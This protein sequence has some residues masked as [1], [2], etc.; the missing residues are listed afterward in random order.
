MARCGCTTECTCRLENGS[1]TTYSGTGTPADPFKIDI[2]VDGDTINC[3]PSGL[4]ATLRTIDTNTV[5][6][7]GDGTVATP[8]E[9][10]VIRTL[11]GNVPDPDAIGTGNLIKEI[12]GP[13]GGIYV[14]CED[15]QDCIGTAITSILVSDCL[16][17]DDATNTINV[18]ICAEPNGVE[19]A[20]SGD[21]DCPTGG[22]L[23][24][25]SSDTGDGLVFGTDN[26]LF[27]ASPAIQAGDCLTITGTGTNADPF[28]IFPQVAPEPNGLECVPG[29]GLLVFPSSDANNG[30]TF[31]PDQRLY[32][33]SCPFLIG[34]S[35]LLFGPASGPCF[36]IQGNGCT[37]P[38]RATLRISS[39]PC[40]GLECRADGLYVNV[41]TSATPA[42]VVRTDNTPGFPGLGPFNGTNAL[43]VVDGPVCINITNPSTCR[44]MITTVNLT[45]FTDV[46]RQSGSMSAQFEISDNAG[47]P[48][49]TVHRNAQAAPTPP[50]RHT[51]NASF[52]GN[53]VLIPPGGSRQVCVRTTVSFAGANTGRLFFSERTISLVGTWAV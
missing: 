30:L 6:L 9:A 7:E 27:F 5:D 28:V 45:G 52:Q 20:P 51:L 49:Q 23:V 3:G 38:L 46:G 10:H 18:L 34:A 44:A 1:C 12:A 41:D 53:D 40:N 29:Q 42:P 26:R 15:V 14:S 13:G 21:P 25:P 16:D 4:E 17:Y 2:I 31:G 19:C 32:V 33:D 47:G 43:L 39:F 35:Q 8:L 11:D 50:S 22:L 48:W 36:E 37:T 24:K